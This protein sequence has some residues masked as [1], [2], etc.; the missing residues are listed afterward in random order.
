MLPLF[1]DTN[2][3]WSLA[4]GVVSLAVSVGGFWL[5]LRLIRKTSLG[6]QQKPRRGPPLA[7]VGHSDGR[8]LS[9]T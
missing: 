5:A 1:T 9:P 4:V 2:I 3:D 6:M 7:Q 8:W